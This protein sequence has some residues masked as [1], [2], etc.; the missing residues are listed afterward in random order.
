MAKKK[1]KARGNFRRVTPQVA[2]RYI[3][4]WE[5]RGVT[6]AD[7]IPEG[8]DQKVQQIRLREALSVM[9]EFHRKME[10][11][12]AEKAAYE[13][14]LAEYKALAKNKVFEHAGLPAKYLHPKAPVKPAMT[15]P[16]SVRGGNFKKVSKKQA[17]SY[18]ARLFGYSARPLDQLSP[19]SHMK[20]FGGNANQ[21]TPRIQEAVTLV[22]PGDAAQ[23]F[24]RAEQN[25]AKRAEK[26]AD[27]AAKKEAAKTKRDATKMAKATKTLEKARKRVADLEAAMA[28]AKRARRSRRKMRRHAR[29]SR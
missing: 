28:G 10:A 11:Y 7:Q 29:R 5:K 1:L 14:K 9:R 13:G 2:E 16:R 17:K 4:F 12:E 26:A 18:L 21:F 20:R 6:K 19:E 23:M 3:K 24:L 25:R 8:K 15:G 22:G 27:A